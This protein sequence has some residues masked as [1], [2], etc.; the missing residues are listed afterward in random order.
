MMH[1]IIRFNHYD[2]YSVVIMVEQGFMFDGIYNASGES[3][4]SIL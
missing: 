1:N 4:P 3:F 2:V